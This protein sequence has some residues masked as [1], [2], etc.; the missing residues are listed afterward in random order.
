MTPLAN[1]TATPNIADGEFQQMQ[2]LI[3]SLCGISVGPDKQYLLESRLAKLLGEY[4]CD[5]FQQF[6]TLCSTRMTPQLKLKLIDAMTTRETLW[7]RDVHPYDTLKNHWLPNLARQRKQ[8]GK[9]VRIWSAACS[10]GQEPYSIAMCVLEYTQQSG[11]T[12]LLNGGLQIKATD[13]APTSILLS[14][15]GRYDAISMARG[16]S[17]ER[18]ARFFAQQG[19]VWQVNDEVKRLVTFEPFNL[20]EDP[21]RLGLFHLIFLRNVAIYFS[22]DFKAQL[23]HRLAK[24]LEPNGALVL[25]ATESLLG[26]TVPL[27]AQRP[28]KTTFYSKSQ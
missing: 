28:D 13:I 17:E 12:C 4:Q 2:R 24:A 3:E 20:Q 19:N 8:T 15:Q 5:T 1:A 18:K 9:P 10:S 7:F 27:V 16:L 11:D 23:F 26:L 22:R 21:G 25:G 14:K 6:H